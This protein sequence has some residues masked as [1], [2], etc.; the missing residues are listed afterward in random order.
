MTKK[1]VEIV[2]DLCYLVCCSVIGA[3]VAT[4]MITSMTVGDYDSVMVFI[5][6]VK[7]GIKALQFDP[8]IFL[9]TVVAF[10]VYL[11]LVI[12]GDLKREL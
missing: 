6:Y 10:I 7:T 1:S 11:I 9:I 3:V 4:P 5:E 8:T 12:I 2:K